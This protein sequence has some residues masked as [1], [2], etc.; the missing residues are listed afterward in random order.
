MAA[1]IMSGSA[2]GSAKT[3]KQSC[4][5]RQAAF[6]NAAQYPAT[7]VS[8]EMVASP[9][10]THFDRYFRTQI[11]RQ[12]AAGP[13]FAGHYV[14]IQW[15]CG[16]GCLQFVI[17]DSLTGKIFH[18]P[19]QTASFHFSKGDVEQE[20]NWQCFDDLLVFSRQSRLLVLEGCVDDKQCGRHFYL[21]QEDGLRE[22]Q[23]DPDVLPNGKIAPY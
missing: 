16:S 17:A 21:M 20:K 12:Y 4:R 22:V 13:N 6:P 5:S 10:I 7:E 23:Y 11:R 9:H 15:G 1:G 14:L 3:S 18:P 8:G 19:V 2:F